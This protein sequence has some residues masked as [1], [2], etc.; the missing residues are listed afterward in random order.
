[1]DTCGVGYVKIL[2]KLVSE[3]DAAVEAKNTETLRLLYK[4]FGELFSA[5]AKYISDKRL[6]ASISQTVVICKQQYDELVGGCLDLHA[7]NQISIDTFKDWNLSFNPPQTKP[8]PK[9]PCNCDDDQT[10]H[11]NDGQHATTHHHAKDCVD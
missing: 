10:P 7:L 11:T 9:S 6:L 4:V 2:S 5:T 8:K 3:F 1:M